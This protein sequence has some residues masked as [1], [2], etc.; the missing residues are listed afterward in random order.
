MDHLNTLMVVLTV[1]A[2]CFKSDREVPSA[3]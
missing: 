1:L 2:R 3:E